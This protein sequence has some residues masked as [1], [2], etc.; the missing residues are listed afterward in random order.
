MTVRHTVEKIGG[1]SMSDY[2]AVRDNIILQPANGDTLYQRIFVVSA[3]GGVTDKLLESKKSGK[4]GVY[5]QFATSIEDDSWLTA[6][7][8]TGNI[9]FDIN[10]SLFEPGERL[11]R[12]NAFLHERINDA[13]EVLLNLQNLCQH[14]HFVLEDHLN[15]VREMLASIGEAHS[16]SNTASLL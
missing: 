12:A 11:E 9:M 15:S 5:A 16:A 13:R 2:A 14:G 10:A 4:P 1:T 3:Y 7:E 8:E 6:L